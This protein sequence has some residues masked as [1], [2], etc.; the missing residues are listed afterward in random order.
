MYYYVCKLLQLQTLTEATPLNLTAGLSINQSISQSLLYAQ[1]QNKQ[2]HPLRYSPILLS[3][4]LTGYI[5]SIAAGLS[6]YRGGARSG[7]G[8]KP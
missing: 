5:A 4:P 3:P 1:R 2:I 7:L 6:G 8:A